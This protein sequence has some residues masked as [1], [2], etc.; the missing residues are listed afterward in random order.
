MKKNIVILVLLVA[1]IALAA[2]A[3]YVRMQRNDARQTLATW[4]QRHE[5]LVGVVDAAID[6]K[7][8]VPE[9]C[10]FVWDEVHERT[11]F[12]GQMGLGHAVLF[13]GA[14]ERD[15]EHPALRRLWAVGRKNYLDASGFDCEASQPSREHLSSQTSIRLVEEFHGAEA[16]AITIGDWVCASNPD[17]VIQHCEPLEG[18]GAR[19]VLT[20]PLGMLVLIL[21]PDE[22]P[23]HYVLHHF[24]Y[25]GVGADKEWLAEQMS[26]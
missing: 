26:Q 11:M 3:F 8:A 17:W 12:D 5:V 21:L 10:P 25:M 16:I 15:K 2:L 4:Q 14:V 24:I 9:D 23:D 20:H 13:V 7:A 22:E 18:G 1:V 6:F 19:A